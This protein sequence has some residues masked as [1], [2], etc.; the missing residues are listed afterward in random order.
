MKKSYL[1]YIIC[2]FL[3]SSPIYSDPIKEKLEVKKSN[4]SSYVTS[5][6][7]TGWSYTCD[8]GIE[9]ELL[10]LGIKNNVPATIAIPNSENVD[11]IVVEIVYKGQNP[12]STITIEDADGNS[13]TANREVPAGGSSNVWYYRTELPATASIN[14]SITNKK[15]KA[16]SMLAYVFRNK[17]N[18]ISSSGV[19]TAIG[20]YNNIQT[21]TIPITTD[22]GPRNVG[23]ELPVSEL[24]PDGR[25]IHIEVSAADGSYAELTEL[26]TGFPDGQCCI[27]VFELNLT[28]VA[29]YVDEI[30][31]KI[32]TRN[33]KNGCN[34]GQSWVMGGAVKTDVHCSCVS[35]GTPP[36]PDASSLADLT[37]ECSVT[38]PTAPTATDN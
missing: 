38:A 4:N 6:S 11:H 7:N 13:Y 26:I 2:A 17:N 14:Y 12:G 9:V 21:I 37:G 5:V 16:Q 8:D 3:I 22:A 31:I 29:G 10:S 25:Y 19:F 28:D 15:D 23:I 27:K 20:G 34:N 1:W 36:E 32:D 35:D 33:G 24:T 18:G 30:V